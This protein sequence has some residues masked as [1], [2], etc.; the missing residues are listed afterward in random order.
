MVQEATLDVQNLN[1]RYRGRT[2]LR[3]ASVQVKRGEITGISGLSGVGK[4][5]LCRSVCG[6]DPGS[7][8]S[9]VAERLDLRGSSLLG[10]PPHRRAKRG[11][12]FVPE[13]SK[14]VSEL[15]VADNITL[16]CRASAGEFARA[17][18]RA[19]QIFPELKP[20]L[21]K[22]AGYLSGGERQMLAIAS[23]LVHNPCLLVVDELSLGLA[24]VV[25]G[26]LVDTLKA[27]AAEGT[28]IL[29]AEQSPSVLLELAN[30]VCFIGVGGET[31]QGKADLILE[32][33]SLMETLFGGE[34]A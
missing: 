24:P 30:E 26:G 17:V 19:V 23:A 20:H 16:G 29:V 13:R 7:H 18:D 14:I 11:V 27:L 5:S 9:V 10:L 31:H 2:V 1:L 34:P 21:A 28:A 33:A 3:N 12:G 4:S 25:L 8:A 15:S 32:E 22:S 6:F